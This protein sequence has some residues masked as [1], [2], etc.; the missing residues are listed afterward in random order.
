MNSVKFLEDLTDN[1]SLLC[2]LT[3]LENVNAFEDEAISELQMLKNI[4]CEYAEEYLFCKN[5]KLKNRNYKDPKDYII[6]V[7]KV[8]SI[9]DL[10][11]ILKCLAK[12]LQCAKED[13]M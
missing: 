6:N 8:T 12:D 3:I 10:I 7:K 13:L 11:D 9:P 1:Y 5:L 4:A 2:E